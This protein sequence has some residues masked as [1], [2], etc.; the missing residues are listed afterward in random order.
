MGF[1]RSSS[2]YVTLLLLG[3]TGCVNDAKEVQ[4]DEV[5][6]VEKLPE[7]PGAGSWTIIAPDGAPTAVEWTVEDVRGYL[8]EMGE[9]VEEGTSTDAA[10]AEC[11]SGEKRI[12]FAGDDFGP[13]PEGAAASDQTFAYVESYCDGGALVVLAGGGLLG[14]QY[15]AYEWL[16]EHGVRYFHPEEEFVP[17]RFEWSERPLKRVHTPD[18]EWRSVSLHLTHPLEL[19]DPIREDIDVY[20]DEVDNYIDWQIK[21]LGSFGLTEGGEVEGR[22]TIRGLPRNKGFSLHNQQQG[23]GAVIDPDSPLTWQEQ[24]AARID[25]IMGNDPGG[26]PHFFSFTFN[27]SEFTELPADLT[28]E[29]LTFIAD[30]IGENY[31]GVRLLTTNHGT[32]GE[33]TELNGLRYYDLPELAPSNLGV[34]VHTL[35]FYDL[36]RPAPVYGAENFNYLYDF[37]ERN[38]QQ[39]EIWHFPEAAWWLTFDISVPL[40]LPITI[41]ARDRD[42]QGIKHMLEGGLTGH[43]TFGSGHEW[44]YWQ[45]EYC[46]FR[47]SADVS[48]R[49]TDCIDDITA[50][51]GPAADEVSAVLQEMVGLQARDFIYD[52]ETLSFLVGTDPETE[53]A[54]DV[55]IDFHPLPPKPEEIGRW[56]GAQV[57][58]FLNVVEPKLKRVQSEHRA[59][60]DRLES[61]EAQVPE[62]GAVWFREVRDGVAA[63]MVRAKHAH[64]VY[65]AAVRFRKSKLE[66]D[67][68]LEEEASESLAAA[69]MATVE[70]A[71]VIR[72]REDD[73]RYRPLN[74]SIADGEENWTVYDYRYLARPNQQYYYRRIDDLVTELIEGGSDP[75]QVEDVVLSTGEPFVLNVVVEPVDGLS[76]DLGDG[77]VVTASGVSHVYDE[78]GVYP[79]TIAGVFEG[80][81]IAQ[82]FDVAVVDES[83]FTGKTGS[84]MKPDISVGSVINGV[85]PSLVVAPT[86]TGQLL[87]AMS[88]DHDD[89]TVQPGEWQAL[90]FSSAWNA[91]AFETAVAPIDIMLAPVGD[92]QASLTIRDAVVSRQ[93]EGS[94][95]VLTGEMATQS[96][97][98]AV[99]ELSGAF[100]PED[101]R[102]LVADA[103]GETS[104]SLPE[105]VDFEV[106]YTVE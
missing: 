84:L 58:H 101:A 91:G 99:V 15:A 102:N 55:G 93:G 30:Y 14:K 78:A 94:D 64:L 13:M 40:Y 68:A 105:F 74:R 103:L 16:H 90:E 52:T 45:N 32:P 24:V 71:R 4:G 89:G 37:M 41:E 29:Q 50:P 28:V 47:L 39:R 76:I 65:G 38:Y 43:R 34:K 62:G 46:S 10:L 98:D 70:A 61:V 27:P 92:K 19:G 59:L 106:V 31:P 75:V 80:A 67:P 49:W 25:S 3:I 36:F 48:Y 7:R 51:M 96:V 8:T 83:V 20:K 22:G 72:S 11:V 23:G 87:F 57:D 56:D 60:L 85:L 88:N 6:E 81:S 35:M 86:S 21:N 17:P 104:D 2:V 82:T 12:V 63:N 66:L 26:W 9:V 33:P 53:L 79:V 54:A 5:S 100:E 42:I 18:F 73:Y 77:T 44:G 97:I 69:K 95:L 1:R